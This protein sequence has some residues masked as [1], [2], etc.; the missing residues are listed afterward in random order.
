[1]MND[2]VMREE[3]PMICD[4]IICNL[5]TSREKRQ[6]LTGEILSTTV[7]ARTINL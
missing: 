4:M 6:Q 5:I 3:I 1:M 7:F 2:D